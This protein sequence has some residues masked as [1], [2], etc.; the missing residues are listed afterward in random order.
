MN[1]NPIHQIAPFCLALALLCTAPIAAQE[2]TTKLT[3]V[4]AVALALRQNPDVVLAHL[5]E[6]AAALDADIQKEPLL[7]RTV[8]G[9]G[10][11]YSSGFPLSMEGAAPSVLRLSATRSL[12]NRVK[13]Y[14]LARAREEARGAALAAASRQNE[15]ALRT[16]ALFL[17]LDLSARS[18]EVA[19]RQV[20]S[21]RRVLET[22]Q[23][24][25]QEGRELPIAAKRGELDLARAQ[26]RLRTLQ[27]NGRMQE[28][29]LAQVLALSPDERI[30]VVHVEN[31]SPAMPA[32]EEECVS[33][34]LENSK[35]IRKLESDLVARGYQVKAERAARLPV[36]DFVADYAMLARFNNYD[37][38]Y[39]TFKRHNFQIGASISIPLFPDSVV[40]ANA[41][42]A[43]IEVSRTRTE[44]GAAR[45]R[46]ATETS[47]AWETLQDAGD[48]LKLARLDLDVA[49]EEVSVSIDKMA[50]GRAT[51]A[52]LEKARFQENEKWL[53]F[54]QAN[55]Q[56]E[57]ARFELL[58]DTGTLI[59]AIRQR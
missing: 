43:E 37:E 19:T 5:D 58:H 22:I 33:Q 44:L 28:E 56:L 41:A 31:T 38:F 23:A 51:L 16:A 53:Q 1:M 18:Q 57:L 6:Q 32:T 45:G 3:I 55:S 20:E 10:L 50:E 26:R 54:F 36:M 29:S 13:T 17:D 14:Q 2:K 48:G 30:E 8:F 27:R 11:A 24:R 40:R 39:N 49:R 34:A 21:L 59:A 9:S 35:E 25:V 42:R 52:D 15:V 46:I 12:F 47:K 4:Q 7:P